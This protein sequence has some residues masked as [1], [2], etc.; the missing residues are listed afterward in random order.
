MVKNIDRSIDIYH[1]FV[2]ALSKKI[3]FAVQEAIRCSLV[4]FRDTD[5]KM[6]INDLQNSI[7]QNVKSRFVNMN[8]W[9]VK[10]YQQAFEGNVGKIQQK[11]S[12]ILSNYSQAKDFELRKDQPQLN[13]SIQIDS[14][15]ISAEM[16]RISENFIDGPMLEVMKNVAVGIV[17]GISSGLLAALLGL[18][19][20]MII[21]SI[22]VTRIVLGHSMTE[23]EKKKKALS[24][25]LDKDQRRKVY[26]E[27]MKEW[28]QMCQAINTSVDKEIRNNQALKKTVDT[29]SKKTLRELA[30][31]CIR[32][33][34]LNLE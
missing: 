2:V 1:P 15:F 5:Q 11:L 7:E 32:E 8:T 18:F 26:D 16:K 23:E 28:N 33:A 17:G 6:S 3:A 25:A 21:G 30:E 4:N 14:T 20:I 19:Y 27:F 34:R 31:I 12:S 9:A 29:Q 24:K 10:C 22:I 13:L